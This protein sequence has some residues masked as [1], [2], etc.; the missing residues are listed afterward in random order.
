MPLKAEKDPEKK[1]KDLAW[2]TAVKA[3]DKACVW[4]GSTARLAADH[5]F[6]R[7]VLSTRW[8]TRNGLALCCGCHLF[9][10]KY[11]PFVWALMVIDKIG[12][13]MARTLQ[14]LHTKQEA[15]R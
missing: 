13:E 15:D 14:L 1:A 5:I 11:E 9:R 12:M 4:C 2:A 7:K 8:D 10:K 6:S 3:R